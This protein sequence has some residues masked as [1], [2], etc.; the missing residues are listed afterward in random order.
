MKTASRPP[1]EALPCPCG[2]GLRYTD[3]CGPLHADKQIAQTA[4]AMMR[5][6]Y[7]AFVLQNE[8]YLLS[9]WHTE[10]R[11]QALDLAEDRSTRWL[12]LSVKRHQILDE[13]HAIVEFVARY[14]IDGR[15]HRLHEIS[16]FVREVDGRWYYRDGDLL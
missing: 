6:R 12:G 4:E 10:T 11:P 3:C 9:T 13:R 1:L 2:S 16:R 7:A 8:A 5:S 15:G 14:R